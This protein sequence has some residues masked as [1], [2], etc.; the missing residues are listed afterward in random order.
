MSALAAQ[1]DDVLILL[2]KAASAEIEAYLNRQLE[3]KDVVERVDGPQG[4]F[5]NLSRY[6]VRSIAS[7]EAGG[8]ALADFEVLMP[9]VGRL[10][11][12]DGWPA[13]VFNVR[14][15]YRG[16]YILPGDEGADLPENIEL[17]C[18][19]Q[20]QSLLRQPGVVSER[21]GDLSV[22]YEGGKMSSA[23]RSLLDGYR[24]FT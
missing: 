13:G 18:I 4:P 15:A 22:T 10:L 20:V 12:E 3:A 7:I 14:I 1:P 6:P 21:V 9:E 17:A 24:R 8:A 19:L 2:I 5:L 11:K 23:V 16:G